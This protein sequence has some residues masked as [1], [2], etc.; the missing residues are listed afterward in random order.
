MIADWLSKFSIKY[1]SS[2]LSQTI[3]IVVSP[4]TFLHLKT[5]LI[6]ACGLPTTLTRDSTQLKNLTFVWCRF[7]PFLRIL[8]LF[9]YKH[10]WQ[11]FEPR[12]L[13]SYLPPT[14]YLPLTS[15]TYMIQ[16]KYSNCE[17]IFW[18]NQSTFPLYCSIDRLLAYY[19]TCKSIWLTWKIRAT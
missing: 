16:M 5:R 2:W 18:M 10:H 3:Y 17:L 15:F 11:E 14:D 19:M 12:S 13:L 9:K 6:L 8:A 7:M 4:L 1:T